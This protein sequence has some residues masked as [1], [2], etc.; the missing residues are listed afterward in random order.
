MLMMVALGFAATARAVWQELNP[1]ANSKSGFDQRDEADALLS[2]VRYLK[3]NDAPLHPRL[4]WQF[5]SSSVDGRPVT[6]KID[7]TTATSAA[8]DDWTDDPA[9]DPAHVSADGFVPIDNYYEMSRADRLV[10]L[11]IWERGDGVG[12]AYRFLGSVD[13]DICAYVGRLRSV[14]GQYTHEVG[15]V[16]F[17]VENIGGEP[18]VT[19]ETRGRFPLKHFGEV[20][21]YTWDEEVVVL[22]AKRTQPGEQA[23]ERQEFRPW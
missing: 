5:T 12:Y 21:F 14:G 2:S 23:L 19:M 18:H 3:A 7:V 15:F 4:L 1:P 11:N 6:L 9:D 17:R 10:A 16:K 8:T 20:A 22:Q 13:D